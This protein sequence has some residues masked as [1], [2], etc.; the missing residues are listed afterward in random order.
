MPVRIIGDGARIW[1]MSPVERLRRMFVRLNMTDV[2]TWDGK[3][4]AADT[5]IVITGEFVF[6]QVLL[7]DLAK[8][9]GTV[10]TLEGRPVAVHCSTDRATEAAEDILAGTLNN[11]SDLHAREPHELSSAYDVALRKNEPPYIMQVSP[12]TVLA[13]EKRT[14]AGSYKGVTDFVT[15]HIWPAPA[16]AVTRWCAQKGITPN[17]VTTA[18]LVLVLLAMGLF[19]NG[20]FGLG[21]IA[22]WVMTFLDTVD[23]KLARVTV[24]STKWGNVYDHGIDLIHPPFWYWAWFVGLTS[25][26][27]SSLGLNIA[28]WVTITGYVIQRIQEGIFIARFRIEM[29]IWRKFDSL[30]RLVVARRNPNLVLLSAFTLFGRPAEGLIAVGIWTF[31]SLVVHSVQIWQALRADQPIKSW[32]DH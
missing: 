12:E 18:S 2:A 4:P 14:F 24:A 3:P 27:P 1:S 29:H 32:L 26:A 31:V 8:Q 15:R 6:A 21:L 19:W 17:A 23:G 13:I 25:L 28:L 7:A 30:Y 9:P 5:C 22:A 16:I 20:Y 10:L 11:I